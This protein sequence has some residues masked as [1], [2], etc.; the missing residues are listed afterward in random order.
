MIR[1]PP[2]STLFPYTTLFRSEG[3]PQGSAR[4]RLVELWSKERKQAVAAVSPTGASGGEV[5]EEGEAPGLGDETASI[6]PAVHG[7]A[8]SSEHPELDHVNPP[9]RRGHSS[10][11]EDPSPPT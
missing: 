7:K 9:R 6:T 5:G 8:Q 2:R 10:D 4:A 11:Y 1:R 3:L